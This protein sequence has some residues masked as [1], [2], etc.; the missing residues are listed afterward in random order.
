MLGGGAPRTSSPV[1]EAVDDTGHP[2]GSGQW[3]HRGVPG[4]CPP[5]LVL[6]EGG[7]RAG[8]GAIR[9]MLRVW[10]VPRAAARS[11]VIP[12]DWKW[13]WVLEAEQFIRG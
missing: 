4:A 12:R 5:A 6:G 13:Q 1:A 3:G 2:W 8:P 10:R 9:V 7:W 11:P